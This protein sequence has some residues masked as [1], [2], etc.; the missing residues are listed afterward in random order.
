MSPSMDWSFSTGSKYTGYFVNSV[1][2]T[3]LVD[4]FIPSSIPVE[5][6][7]RS[8]LFQGVHQ[9]IQP[10]AA[11]GLDLFKHSG[12]FCWFPAASCLNFIDFPGG[13]WALPVDP[14][15]ECF[16]GSIIRECWSAP[17]WSHGPV[18][19]ISLPWLRTA[20]SSP[21]AGGGSHVTGS[22][23]GRVSLS[24]PGPFCLGWGLIIS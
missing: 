14:I 9:V 6:W 18:P 11:S 12:D 13:C 20:G 22:W 8:A 24:Q 4:W 7:V 19:W 3:T 5:S 16:D 1:G 21:S 10:I 23:C 2:F 15:V 17:E